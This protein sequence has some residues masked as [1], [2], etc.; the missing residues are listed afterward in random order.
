M[1]RTALFPSMHHMH[2][3]GNVGL[4]VQ[5]RII[6]CKTV[7][8]ADITAEWNKENPGGAPRFESSHVLAVLY[9]PL[10]VH[11]NQQL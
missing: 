3:I 5:E 7:L 4:Y 8:F 9:S 2:N 10:E 6:F 1:D 11:S